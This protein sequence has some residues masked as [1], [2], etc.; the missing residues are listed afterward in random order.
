MKKQSFFFSCLLLAAAVITLPACRKLDRLE[1]IFRDFDKY[2][3]HCRITRIIDSSASYGSGVTTATFKYNKAGDPVSILF[4]ESG[5][6]RP[7]YLFWYDQKGR[8]SDYFEAYISEGVWHGCERW[9]HYVYQGNRIVQDTAWSF[10][11]VINNVPQR[12]QIYEVTDYTYDQHD[13]ITKMVMTLK[14]GSQVYVAS[15]IYAYNAQGNLSSMQRWEG[16]QLASEYVYNS[17]DDKP[18]VHRTHKLWKFLARNY[19]VNNAFPALS[20][21]QYKLPLGFHPVQHNVAEFNLL[22]K[23]PL[24]H[25]VISYQCK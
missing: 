18:A 7:N 16:S 1:D 19:S 21:N 22:D 5:T 25:S 23:L 14:V 20:Y 8:I 17:Y 24:N 2:S 3:G 9:R 10:V 4:D 11:N 6:G 13:R 12:G 15:Y